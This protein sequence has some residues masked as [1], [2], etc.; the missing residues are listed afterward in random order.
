MIGTLGSKTRFYRESV[1]KE[2]FTFENWWLSLL[3]YCFTHISEPFMHSKFLLESLSKT[4]PFG[5][6]LTGLERIMVGSGERVIKY[7]VKI[8]RPE[9]SPLRLCKTEMDKENWTQT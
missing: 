5:L 7:K 6:N 1:R 2:V 4:R 3:N 8:K 9:N